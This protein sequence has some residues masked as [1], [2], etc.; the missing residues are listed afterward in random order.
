MPLTSAAAK[1]GVPAAAAALVGDSH[2]DLKAARAAGY[3]FI[4]ATYGYGKVDETELSSAARIARFADLGTL[5]ALS[6]GTQK[7]RG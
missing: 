5:A 4:W 2:Q 3:S 7:P 1:F 6:G